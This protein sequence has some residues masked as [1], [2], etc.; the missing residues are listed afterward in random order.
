M[1]ASKLDRRCQFWRA[2][3][4]DDGMSQ[5]QEWSKRGYPVWAL[6]ED[7][8]DGERWR[9]GEVQ[10]SISTRFQV[11]SSEFTRDIDARDRIECEGE[12]FEIV[13]VKQASKYGRRQ[14]IEITAVRRNDGG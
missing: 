14:L 9:A 10:A 3:L 7:V 8:S 13:G 6:R 1:M 4:V 11:R 12:L 5:V 2:T